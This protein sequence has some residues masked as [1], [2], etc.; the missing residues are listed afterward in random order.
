MQ[1]RG[2]SSLGRP[3]GRARP[4]C[5]AGALAPGRVRQESM[6]KLQPCISQ[7][8][9]L[10]GVQDPHK[11]ARAQELLRMN[12]EIKKAKKVRGCGPAPLRAAALACYGAGL[13]RALRADV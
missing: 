10:A 8:W 9:L 11:F 13:T 2:M 4:A 12:E 3:G 1:Q 7:L 5:D 6:N